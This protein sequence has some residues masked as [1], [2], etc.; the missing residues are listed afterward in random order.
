MVTRVGCQVHTRSIAS[1]VAQWPN[2]VKTSIVNLC[3]RHHI[4]QPE[5]IARTFACELGARSPWPTE[6]RKRY[7]GLFP[8]HI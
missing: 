7:M 8:K 1:G 6:S 2:H 4:S 5:A 3:V